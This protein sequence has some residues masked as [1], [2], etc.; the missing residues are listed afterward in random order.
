MKVAPSVESALHVVA[1]LAMLPKGATVTASHLAQFHDLSETSTAKLLQRLATEGI[2]EAQEGRE[3]GYTL[4]RP[5]DQIDLAEIVAAAGGK[6]PGFRCREI[7][8]QGPCAGPPE[9]YSPRCTIAIA[10]H[11]AEAAW[12]AALGQIDIATIARRISSDVAPTIAR[13][14]AVWF[15][16]RMRP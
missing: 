5:A 14:S 4:A 3:G 12:W 11:E 13:D 15:R 10:M 7:R 9:A 2:V 1:L 16:E 8:Q 6:G